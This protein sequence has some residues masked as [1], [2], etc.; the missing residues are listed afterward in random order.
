MRQGLGV[1]LD[2]FCFDFSLKICF[3]GIVFFFVSAG[4]SSTW[5]QKQSRVSPSDYQ[6][7]SLRISF[8]TGPSLF[9]SLSVRSVVGFPLHTPAPTL[10]PPVPDYTPGYGFAIEGT[11]VRNDFAK[12][13][14]PHKMNYSQSTKPP[15]LSAQ[16]PP[17]PMSKQKPTPV[18]PTRGPIKRP[19][20]D[21]KA[22]WH[23][24]RSHCPVKRPPPGVGKDGPP[25]PRV[26]AKWRGS[27]PPCRPPPNEQG[28]IMWFA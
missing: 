10:T 3:A 11:E 20:D 15:F 16:A 21:Y 22:Q 24:N 18:P 17:M 23:T 28:Q 1:F 5:F 2:H 27:L 12:H 6:Y 14:P 4:S 8:R 9:F 25:E 13:P 26:G 7:S 19:P